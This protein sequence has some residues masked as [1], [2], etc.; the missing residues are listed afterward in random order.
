MASRTAIS[1]EEE[2]DLIQVLSPCDRMTHCKRREQNFF[3]QSLECIRERNLGEMV[4]P[5]KCEI[6]C[7]N[8]KTNFDSQMYN[9]FSRI[10]L[11][12]LY[13]RRNL[14]L[15]ASTYFHLHLISCYQSQFF[16]PHPRLPYRRDSSAC[17]GV[18]QRRFNLIY[19]SARSFYSGKYFGHR[20]NK[21]FY[22]N[23]ATNKGSR[24]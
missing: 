21:K 22:Y 19:G 13:H 5:Q 10:P 15:A 2:K 17:L 14:S 18:V 3:L 23:Y 1:Q 20:N 11:A 7:F 24:Q 8:L 4:P 16:A 6:K 9:T 12:N